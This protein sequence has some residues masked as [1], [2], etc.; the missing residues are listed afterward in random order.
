MS[1]ST[2]IS[3]PRILRATNGEP[4]TIDQIR[5]VAPA[6]FQAAPSGEV[7]ERYAYIPTIEVLQ[8]LLEEGY[9]VHEVAQASSHT[10]DKHLYSKHM[11]RMRPPG[12]KRELKARDATP[13]IVLINAHDGSARYHLY[14]GLYRF[15][16][17][18]GLVVGDTFASIVV[19]HRGILTKSVVIEGSY[20]IVKEQ[21]PRVLDLKDRMMEKQTTPEGRFFLANNALHL[22][23]PGQVPAFTPGQLLAPRRHEDSGDDIWSVLNRV[24]ENV[25]EGGFQSLSPWGRRTN[26]RPITQVGKRVDINRGLWMAAETLL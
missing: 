25:M 7:S 20:T 13:E 18:N 10:R 23:Y 19:A 26:I 16:C 8:G 22:R 4:L 6:V 17:C 11:L 24:Q 15:I 2:R 9:T 1:S 5:H 14:S 12:P 21:F 3:K